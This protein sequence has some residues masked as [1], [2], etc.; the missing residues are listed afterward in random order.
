LNKIDPYSITS[1]SISNNSSLSACHIQIICEYLASP[2]GSIN[3]SYNDSGC[4]SIIELAQACGGELPCLPYGNYTLLS[5]SDMDDFP[6]IFPDCSDLE[7][8]VEIRNIS[9]LNGISDVTTIGGDLRIFHCDILNNLA[10]ID[11]IDPSSITE[12]E[13]RENDLLSNCE[14][15]SICSFLASPNASIWIEN[16]APGCNSQEEVEEAC[17]S[18]T[19]ADMH[20]AE[21]YSIYPNPTNSASTISYY[22]EEDSY[23]S[24]EI[25]DITGTRVTSLVN[26]SQTAG[27]QQLIWN[28]SMIPAGIYLCRMRIGTAVTTRKIVRMK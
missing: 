25:Y 15:E 12:I 8:G 3:I 9:N 10:G 26:K 14:V 21:N 16:N 13:I 5:Q 19:G 6:L 18:I 27:S 1:L 28:T 20:V 2:N 23:V 7:G 11:N 17:D 4:Y 22:L 24:I